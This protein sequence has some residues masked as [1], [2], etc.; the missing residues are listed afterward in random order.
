MAPWLW[1]GSAGR[2]EKEKNENCATPVCWVGHDVI[3]LIDVRVLQ[4]SLSRPL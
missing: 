1:S 4:V 3:V 2:A